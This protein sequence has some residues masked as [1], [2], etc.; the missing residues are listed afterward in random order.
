MPPAKGVINV[1]VKM[2]AIVLTLESLDWIII[3][4]L[5]LFIFE[6]FGLSALDLAWPISADL[7]YREAAKT[8]YF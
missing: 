5:P 6:C 2:A 4:K 3:V 8:H 1:V 7:R